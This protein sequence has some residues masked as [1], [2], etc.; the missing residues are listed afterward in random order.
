MFLDVLKIRRIRE[1]NDVDPRE[2]AG[3]PLELNGADDSGLGGGCDGA[4]EM[5]GRGTGTM[6][7]NRFG[8]CRFCRFG[9]PSV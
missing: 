7:L 6:S 3:V 8:S 2:G 5:D 1:V 9:L 4:G